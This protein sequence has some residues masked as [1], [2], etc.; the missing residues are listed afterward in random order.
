MVDSTTLINEFSESALVYEGYITIRS[1]STDNFIY[2]KYDQLMELTIDTV[3]E[4]VAHFNSSKKKHNVVVGN[5]S[6]A[7][8]SIKDTVDLYQEDDEAVDTNLITHIIKELNN[9]LRVVPTV[10][11]GIQKSESGETTNFIIELLEGDIVAVRKRRNLDTGDYTLE[12]EFSVN[13]RT[14]ES[15]DAD[16][17]PVPS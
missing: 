5:N 10:F 2:K 11:T 14:P 17:I 16:P 4:I 3:P 8:I 7:I 12:F 13:K 15:I 6:V 9:E 1:G